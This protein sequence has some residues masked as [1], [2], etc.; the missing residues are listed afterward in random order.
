MVLQGS[1]AKKRNRSKVII[2]LF[3]S[4]IIIWGLMFVLNYYTPLYFDDFRYIYSWDTGER[5]TN[6]YQIIPSMK[7]HY[8]TMNGRIPIHFLAQLFLLI[9]PIVFDIIN[10]L[11]F[12]LFVLLICYYASG[13][14]VNISAPKFLLSFI[15]IWFFTPS[16]GE[17]FLWL[18]GSANYMFGP[19]I[20]LSFLYPY[21]KLFNGGFNVRSKFSEAAFTFLYFFWGVL[22]GWT[23]ENISLCIIIAQVLFV[24][25][26]VLSKE[27]FRIWFVS[28]LIGNII[29]TVLLFS[30]P[31]Y[32]KRSSIWS[33]SFNILSMIR[34]WVL[35]ISSFL[36]S[37]FILILLIIIFAILFLIKAK[38][39]FNISILK[40]N[41][42]AF[43]FLLTSFAYIASTIACDYFPDRAWT[44]CTALLSIVLLSMIFKN[45]KIN[46]QHIG[47]YFIVFASLIIF[48]LGPYLNVFL[49]LK[50]V[51]YA[52][53]EREKQIEQCLQMNKKEIKLKPIKT[54]NPY[55]CYYFGGDIAEDYWMNGVLEKY[56]GIKIIVD[57]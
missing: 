46:F 29:G 8:Q 24:L 51:N 25:I 12:S 42:A 56:Y 6:I 33:G 15:M 47:A 31:S 18:T 11:S 38:G 4:F 3:L 23:N 26:S 49:D 45:K 16:F 20:A 5:I 43:V 48:V 40:E 7:A 22:A 19:L 50:Q 2:F 52:F 53:N 41:A 55:S 9:N 21:V 57:E 1:S 44:P 13:S 27:N 54:S 30:S 17:S 35:S 39:H 32:V 28:G 34:N 37:A 36:K 14:F 10:S